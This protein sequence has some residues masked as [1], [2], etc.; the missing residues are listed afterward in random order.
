MTVSQNVAVEHRVMFVSAIHYHELLH[1][2][3]I[4]GSYSSATI[5]KCD[6][7]RDKDRS[8]AT[9]LQLGGSCRNAQEAVTLAS[10]TDEPGVNNFTITNDTEIWIRVTADREYVKL[11][12]HHGKVVGALLIGETDLEEAIENLILDR[13]DVSGIGIQL[14]DPSVD[15][16]DYFD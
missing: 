4:Q 2:C 12:V 16:T 13:L 9:Q 7:V 14:L 10:S 6:E 5:E 8:T 15:M 3:I 1:V 11:V